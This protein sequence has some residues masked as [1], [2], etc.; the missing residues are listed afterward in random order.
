M[1]LVAPFRRCRR[2]SEQI[3]GRGASSGNREISGKWEPP[4]SLRLNNN[5]QELSMRPLG[6]VATR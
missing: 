2:I 5:A 4:K 3:V 6:I 1:L